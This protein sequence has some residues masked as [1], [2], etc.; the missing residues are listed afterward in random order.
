MWFLRPNFASTWGTSTSR[1]R[2]HNSGSTVP[3]PAKSGKPTR[4]RHP[5][6]AT[7]HGVN[8]KTVA[9]WRGRT[10]T[11]DAL[12]GPKPASPAL[13]AEEE[14]IAV[15]GRQHTQLPLDD[16]LYA[17]QETTPHLS[18]PALHRLF[19]RRGIGRLPAPG[20][21]EKKKKFKDRPIGYPH[22]D[23]AEVHAEEGRVYLLVAL[24]RTRKLAFAESPPRAPPMLAADFLRR[25]PAAVPYKG[26]KVLPDN[27]A[28]FGNMPPRG[29]AWRHIFD[30]VCDEHGVEQRFTKPA[31]PWT[32]GRGERFN[33]T[34]KEAAGRRCHYQTTA[35]R[36]EH[37]QAF[38]LAHNHA[39]R[40]ERLRGKTPHESI[41]QQRRLNPPSFIRDP[42]HLTL[43]LYTSGVRTINKR[44][45][46]AERS[47]SISAAQVTQPLQ[48]RSRDA[49]T[50]SA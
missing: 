12:T 19:Q 7:R 29:D 42:T 31:H 9:K 40:L 11:A 44:S 37:P 8:P 26:H 14:A 33:R 30:R 47:R 21:A 36:N 48:R 28:P 16:C 22:V 49:S 39:K 38:L 4:P 46:H 41:C 18:R 10:T 2:P 50:S 25:A 32:N 24:D 45:C 15:A 5:P 3:C 17:L 27:G 35:Q 1:Q 23:F 34:L 43:G 13:T 6:P 20:P